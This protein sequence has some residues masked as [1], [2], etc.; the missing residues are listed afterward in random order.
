MKIQCPVECDTYIAE[1]KKAIN[2]GPDFMNCEIEPINEDGSFRIALNLRPVHNNI[3]PEVVADL[4]KKFFHTATEKILG[5]ASPSTS[6]V[7]STPI[8]VFLNMEP[9]RVAKA[10]QSW[11]EALLPLQEQDRIEINGNEYV[12]SDI[13]NV[14]A[15]LSTST[16]QTR[17]VSRLWL[18]QQYEMQRL[19]IA[20]SPI[21]MKLLVPAGV[22]L[23]KVETIKEMFPNLDLGKERIR[24]QKEQEPLLFLGQS[25]DI[26]I[27]ID[28]SQAAFNKDSFHTK[29]A[30]NLGVPLDTL[31]TN[32]Q[33][34]TNGG[35]SVTVK[36]VANN[37]FDGTGDEV[38][39]Y[40]TSFRTGNKVY[41]SI[42]IIGTQDGDKVYAET[43]KN[44]EVVM[45][46][47]GKRD[48]NT[49]TIRMK[50]KLTAEELGLPPYSLRAVFPVSDIGVPLRMDGAIDRGEISSDYRLLLYVDREREHMSAAELQVIKDA[51]QT[52]LDGRNGR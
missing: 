31:S 1:L 36:G 19:T 43:L 46:Q 38:V 2:E 13:N 8:E 39:V 25:D 50:T 28:V 35:V 7:Q 9:S 51:L 14:A 11:M 37:I 34:N 10:E 47:I 49:G 18:V 16:G 20:T 4:M 24:Q 22:V 5:D 26:I 30:E 17:R 42:W 15:T 3:G 45:E 40:T 48:Y 44:G 23:G 33:A 29:L 41:D 27:D 52:E 12:L 6:E 21:D 32:V